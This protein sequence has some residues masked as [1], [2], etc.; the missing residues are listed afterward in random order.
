MPLLLL[1]A[2]LAVI[3]SLG[4]DWIRT[5]RDAV[6]LQRD[7]T[8]SSG[9][10]G[11]EP[12]DLPAMTET[13]A[14]IPVYLVGAVRRPGIYQVTIGTYLYELVEQAGGLTEDA[15]AEAIDLVCRIETNQLIRLPTRAETAAGVEPQLP[16]SGKTNAL[17]DINRADQTALETLPGVGPATAQAIIA[18]RKQN[19]LFARIEDLMQVPG[20][21]EARFE[22]LKDRI[23]VSGHA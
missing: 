2:S 19:G 11:T 17:I 10:A 15:D 6:V 14:L 23:C 3:L 21:K 1:L 8:A 20:I 22:A 12:A 5:G 4:W 9:V 16:S 13:A 7:P 18:Y